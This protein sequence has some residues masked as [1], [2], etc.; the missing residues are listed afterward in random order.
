MD[1]KLFHL[2]DT[3]IMTANL[4]TD[5]VLAGDLGTIVE[6]YTD[7][8]PAYEVEFVNPNGTTRALL[9]LSP[10]QIRPLSE[11][12]VLTTRQSALAA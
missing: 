7:P 12:D 3:V 10:D 1:N 9:T 8:S 11:N 5:E 2:L 4:S 6:I